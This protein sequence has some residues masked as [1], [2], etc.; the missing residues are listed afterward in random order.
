MRFLPISRSFW[1][2]ILVF[3]LLSFPAR[4]DNSDW[5]ALARSYGVSE[6]RAGVMLHDLELKYGVPFAIETD[7]LDFSKWQNLSAEVLFALPDNDMIRFLGSPRIGLGGTLN[8]VGK[9]SYARFAAVWHVP[10]FDT[11]LF[12]EPMLGG[13]VHDGY[14][15]GA[16]PDQ[17]NLGCRLL[18][19][20]GANIGYD[21]S[22]TVDVM[23]TFEHG[24]HWGQCDPTANDG[25]NRLGI[26]VGWKLN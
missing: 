7:S 16:P 19:F 11:G 2:A 18:Y 25:I 9:E 6:L 24:S 15:H 1:L 23:L 12:V 13:M 14:L 26:R 17:R 8:F 5:Q 21:L 22:T 3:C 4:A 20:Y 10:V